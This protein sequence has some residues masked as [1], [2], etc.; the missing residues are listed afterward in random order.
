MCQIS[1]WPCSKYLVLY[2]QTCTPKA[3][4]DE[5]SK[6]LYGLLAASLKAGRATTFKGSCSRSAEVMGCTSAGTATRGE[7]RNL[8][9]RVLAM[10]ATGNPAGLGTGSF[11][12]SPT[13]S[14]RPIIL[15][16]TP[17]KYEHIPI[18]S[19]EVTDG[20]ASI[21]EISRWPETSRLQ[22][23]CCAPL[24]WRRRDC[25]ISRPGIWPFSSTRGCMRASGWRESNFR[26]G[27]EVLFDAAPTAAITL[28]RPHAAYGCAPAGAS[29]AWS[30]TRR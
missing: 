2:S 7:S 1:T 8:P 24:L 23:A 4:S 19:C 16:I 18:P 27:G 6:E 14:F 29:A 25:R 9:C 21:G 13:L 12:H 17:K 30:Q 10:L 11:A 20:R 5:Y 15:A 26:N 22:G 28:Q 3:R